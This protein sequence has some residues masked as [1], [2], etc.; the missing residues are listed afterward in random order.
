MRLFLLHLQEF[1]WKFALKKSL[2]VL[3]FSFGSLSAKW[4]FVG[5]GTVKLVY[6]EV[7]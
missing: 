3:P 7:P 5:D 6:R 1:S 4:L 2:N